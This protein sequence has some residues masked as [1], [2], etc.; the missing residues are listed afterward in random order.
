MTC[1]VCAV[2]CDVHLD[3]GIVFYA[4]ILLSR[5][6]YWCVGWQYHDTVVTGTYANLIFGTDHTE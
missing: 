5:H 6:T 2:R 3:E 4:E 1:A